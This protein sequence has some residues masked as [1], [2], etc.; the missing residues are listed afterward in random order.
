MFKLG[1]FVYTILGYVI[2]FFPNV[3]AAEFLQYGACCLVILFSFYLNVTILKIKI[4]LCVLIIFC[5]GQI[6]NQ[7]P[8]KYSDYIIELVK[9]TCI[10]AGYLFLITGGFNSKKYNLDLQIKAEKV[11]CGILF[12]TLIL[13]LLFITVPWLLE[14]FWSQE[15]AT[16]T[17]NPI[18]SRARI[19]GTFANPN[20]LAI[21]C[22][23]LLL[24]LT[25]LSET[26]QSKKAHFFVLPI[27]WLV[28]LTGSKTGIVILFVFLISRY[29]TLMLIV[30][31]PMILASISHIQN[32]LRTMG[33]Y[34]R[35]RF[36][37]DNSALTEGA[38]VQ[39]RLITWNIAYQQI[40]SSLWGTIHHGFLSIV[41]NSFILSV[42]YLGPIFGPLLCFMMLFGC[43]FLF[44][45][46]GA[47]Q[48]AIFVAICVI[49]GLTSELL[50]APKFIAFLIFM[51]ALIEFRERPHSA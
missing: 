8:L 33:E 51:K 4:I 26:D 11:I 14:P 16:N 34:S 46:L 31:V 49:V 47:L 9:L 40:S 35:Y 22:V 7:T 29:F 44:R 37:V 45:D 25:Y 18:A 41:D 38:S 50:M 3:G 12:V 39:D 43:F 1:T 21:Y 17:L 32:F 30:I 23:M 42:L 27:S 6:F 2:F 20:H 48:S 28:L 24:L 10:F 5:A 15:K 36:L 19:V 13:Q